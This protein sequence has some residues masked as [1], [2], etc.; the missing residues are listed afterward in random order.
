MSTT[1]NKTYLK[2]LKYFGFNY[3][4]SKSIS[5]HP[6]IIKLGDQFSE[7]P[8][9]LLSINEA[10]ITFIVEW[11]RNFPDPIIFDV[12]AHMGYMSTQI[13]QRLNQECKIF[14]FEPTLNTFRILCDSIDKLG[15]NRQVIPIC[16]ALDKESG[17]VS[18]ELSENERDSMLNRIS[19]IN[20]LKQNNIT[21]STT[22]DM[23]AE[24]FNLIPNVIKI[25]VEGY[26]LNVLNGSK[27]ILMQQNK[28]AILIEVNPDTLKNFNL[29]V[30]DLYEALDGYRFYYVDDY[31]GQKIPIAQEIINFEALKWVCN[32][33]CVPDN[34]QSLNQWKNT[35]PNIL[36]ILG[37]I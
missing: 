33:F 27:S 24:K 20:D 13:A 8:F 36:N 34:T 35:K 2:V 1:L 10:E 4:K 12:G 32:I 11:C 30:N 16:A 6:Y 3:Y 23:F 14:A 25:D 21:V 26:E 19:K 17:F 5:G 7:N 29:S 37:R 31:L 15:L 18:I 9:L 22:I 28:P